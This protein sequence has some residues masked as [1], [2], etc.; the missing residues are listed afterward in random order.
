LRYQ[1]L[2]AAIDSLLAKGAPQTASQTNPSH[3]LP[4]TAGRVPEGAQTPLSGQHEAAFQSTLHDEARRNDRL[5]LVAEDNETNQKLILRQLALLGCSADVASN[6]SQ[7]LQRW[8][9]G[10]Y[11][12]LLSD[13]HMPEMDGYELATAIRALEQDSRRIPI[14]AMTASYVKGDSDHCRAADVDDY[15]SKPLQL[16]DLKATLEKWLPAVASNT[17]THSKADPQFA[18]V[19]AVDVSVL[20]SLVG[21][22]PAVIL[23]FLNDFQISAARIAPDLITACASRKALQASEQAHKLMSSARSVGALALGELCAE[24]ETAG[25]AGSTETLTA[26]L[27]M[28]ERELGAVKAFL[29][30]LQ[31]Q[32]ADRLSRPGERVSGAINARR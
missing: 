15:L 10:N 12:L 13:L 17:H 8:Q 24:M 25:K 4:I 26:L 7:A 28:F 1:E 6:G 18:A 2:Y 22:D 27:P 23:E 3:D 11:A 21:N 29:D 20:E 5:I 16:A 32:R 30:S 14:V 31:A 19:G 9:T